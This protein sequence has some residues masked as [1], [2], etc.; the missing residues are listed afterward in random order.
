M[1]FT[2]IADI[3]Q[4]MVKKLLQRQGV[5]RKLLI[6]IKFSG[7]KILVNGKERNAIFRLSVGDEL[8]IQIP[9]ELAN[10]DLVP[11]A[12]P[13]DIAYE[14]EDYLIIN[15]PAGYVSITAIN[16]RAGSIC[17]F[18]ADYLITN[19]YENQM[20]HLVTRLDRNTSGL[21]VFA[22]HSFAHSV[23]IDQ[24]AKFI[25]KYFAL[26]KNDEKLEKEALINLPIGRKEGSIIE[27]QVRF[28]GLSEAKEARTSYQLVEVKNKLSLLDLTLH[29]GRTHQIRVHLSY[30]GYPLLGDDLYGG[31]MSLISRQ[32]LHC[33]QVSFYNPF[34]KKQIFVESEL[35]KD[36]NLLIK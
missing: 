4:Q 35:P 10:P 2:Y 29:T 9:N 25:K 14:D 32:A 36:M 19:N 22:K 20:V 1:E 8:T 13:L 27:R 31:D 34:R 18:V 7:G 17:N 11:E 24:R 26:V 5:S 15:K 21:M 28:D 30:L 12:Y 16:A 33:H 23:L 6:K 3:D